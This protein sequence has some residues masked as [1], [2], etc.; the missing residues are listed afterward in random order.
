MLRA[1]P[2]GQAQLVGPQ[3]RIGVEQEGALCLAHA[4]DDLGTLRLAA[5]TQ[6]L[7]DDGRLRLDPL[8]TSTVGLGEIEPAFQRLLSGDGAVKILVDPRRA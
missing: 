7:V 2:E 3:R 5:L 8:H 4:R 1:L 6:Q